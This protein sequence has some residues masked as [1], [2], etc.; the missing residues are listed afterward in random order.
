MT[1]VTCLAVQYHPAVVARR[2]GDGAAVVRQPVH[3]GHRAR[4]NLNAHLIG[5]GWPPVTCGTSRC[6]KR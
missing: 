4:Q 2:S 1:H 6:G 5:H 3:A